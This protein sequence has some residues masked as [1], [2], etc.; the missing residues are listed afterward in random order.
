MGVA[1]QH[2][3]V[4]FISAIVNCDGTSVRANLVNMSPD[5]AAIPLRLKLRF[6]TYSVGF[7]R[8]GTQA[9]GFAFEPIESVDR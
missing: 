7:D 9:I 5:P 2:I 8:E 3:H 6:V 1:D 4:P